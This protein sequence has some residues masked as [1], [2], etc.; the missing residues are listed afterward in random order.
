MTV[1]GCGKWP[2]KGSEGRRGQGGQGGGWIQLYLHHDLQRVQHHQAHLGR[3]VSVHQGLVFYLFF[4]PAGGEGV[5]G[6][7]PGVVVVEGWGGE[8]SH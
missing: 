8:R 7:G 5:A 1:Y 4:A 2:V 6:G 3:Q